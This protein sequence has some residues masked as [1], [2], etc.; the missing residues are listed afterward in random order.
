MAKKKRQRISY[1]RSSAQ[2]SKALTDRVVLPLASRPGGHRLGINGLSIDH[3]RNIL[4]VA[5]TCLARSAKGD[6]DILEVE[7]V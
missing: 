1:G 6:S 3:D 4:C 7:T 2:T 5:S